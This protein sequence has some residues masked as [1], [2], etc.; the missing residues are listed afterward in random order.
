MLRLVVGDF[1]DARGSW[2]CECFQVHVV[3]GESDTMDNIVAGKFV[4]QFVVV[5]SKLEPKFQAPW[6]SDDPWIVQSAALIFE[7]RV[8]ADS[9]VCKSCWHSFV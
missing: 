3:D 1:V 5:N 9:L 8:S 2:P 4:G 7:L 6:A